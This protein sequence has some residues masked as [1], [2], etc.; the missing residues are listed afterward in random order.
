MRD[1]YCVIGFPGA[2]TYSSNFSKAYG[3]VKG[4]SG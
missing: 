3:L 1:Q 2:A 4:W